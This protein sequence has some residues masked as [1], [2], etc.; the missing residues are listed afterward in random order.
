MPRDHRSILNPEFRYYRAVDTDLRRTF[1]RIRREMAK[2]AEA[3]K[4]SAGK[5]VTPIEKA[6][7]KSIVSNKQ[8]RRSD[9]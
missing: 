6:R 7:R 5:I 9:T 1:A 8:T 4:E 2:A 3:Q